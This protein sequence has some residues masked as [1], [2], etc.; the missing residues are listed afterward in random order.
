[1]DMLVQTCALVIDRPKGSAHPRYPDFRYPLDYGYL[2]GTAS[3][4]GMGI[5]VW[6]GSLPE[7]RVTALLCAVDLGKRDAE[8]KLLL[9]CTSEEARQVLAIHN[10]GT[11]SATLLERPDKQ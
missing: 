10:K 3:G 7:K 1:L 2:E 5:D 4:D 6:V 8:M 11:Q 9:G